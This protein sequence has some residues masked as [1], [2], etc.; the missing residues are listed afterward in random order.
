MT[1]TTG[2]IVLLCAIWWATRH[3]VKLLKFVMYLISSKVKLQ[4]TT[5]M[6]YT[7]LKF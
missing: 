1:T 5:S 3:R 4:A 2:P 6:K 7:I